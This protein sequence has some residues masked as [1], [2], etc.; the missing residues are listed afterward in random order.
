[1]TPWGIADHHVVAAD[2]LSDDEVAVAA[3]V[4]ERDHGHAELG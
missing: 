1:M 3:G 2:A 4:V